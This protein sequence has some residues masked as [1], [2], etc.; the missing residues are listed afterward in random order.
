MQAAQQL[1]DGQVL[2]ALRVVVARHRLVG[3]R[4]E[5]GTRPVVAFHRAVHRVRRALDARDRLDPRADEVDRREGADL[6][7]EDDREALERDRATLLRAEVALDLRADPAAL[8]RELAGDLVELVAALV[9]VGALPAVQPS[10]VTIDVTPGHMRI[11]ASLR[12]AGLTGPSV[13]TRGPPW[14]ST[15]GRVPTTAR[16][17]PPPSSWRS[18]RLPA[19]PTT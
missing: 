16:V 15:P 10:D 12:S 11:T 7:V 6:A 14:S 1:I 19:P 18:R 4:E 8:V 13:R 3:E 17:P 9:V 2:H 5:A